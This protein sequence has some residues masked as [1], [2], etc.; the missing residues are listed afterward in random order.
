MVRVM[1]FA[2]LIANNFCFA[3]Q[4]IYIQPGLLKAS[5]TIGASDV[6]SN[7]DKNYYLT[8]F[9][10]YFTTNKVSVRGDVF[11]MIPISNAQI[12]VGDEPLMR[13]GMR[14]FFGAFYHFTKGNLDCNF[15]FQPGLS[16]LDVRNVTPLNESGYSRITSP[17][18][19]LQTG[20]TFYVW[21]YF[22]F[23]AQLNYVKSNLF[24]ADK[25]AHNADELIFS[26]GLG[27]QIQTSRKK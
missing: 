16:V 5:G 22:H 9:T 6:L 18:F 10:E 25:F 1:F 3:Q 2:L 27:F 15:G 8:G 26:G 13:G 7:I 4:E 21:K 23:Y 14:T 11:F 17:G 24:G 19:N 20:V 12:V